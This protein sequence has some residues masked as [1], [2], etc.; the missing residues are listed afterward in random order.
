MLACLLHCRSSAD[1]A[2]VIITLQAG[3]EQQP[4]PGSTVAL[5]GT[6]FSTQQV[7]ATDPSSN[8][9]VDPDWFDHG[10]LTL[11]AK[12]GI[13]VGGLALLL[14]VLGF[15]I[16]WNGKRR[17]KAFLRT[18]EAKH[19]HNG[20]PSP[21]TNI[22]TRTHGGGDMR[23]TPLSQR[24]LRG[25]DDSPMT[26]NTEQTFPRYF[27]P[28]SSQYNSPIS[29]NDGPSMPWPPVAAQ[30]NQSIGLAISPDGG[31]W[32]RSADHR[33]RAHNEGAESYEM[34]EVDSAGSE[35]ASRG[36]QRMQAQPPVLGH[37]GYGRS[38]NSPP[39]TYK[40]TEDD[41]RTGAAF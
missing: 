2:L 32:D 10:P 33:D 37:P 34:H 23:E 11:G 27:S 5:D 38:E 35:Q 25:W 14:A 24:P 15:C 22:N 40:L 18:L 12:V 28:Y 19:G 7:N 39:R 1:R 20:W 31:N 30:H 6:V 13:A 4:A 8:A 36:K 9:E 17:R 16:V 21:A 41:A 3:C 26:A 29:A